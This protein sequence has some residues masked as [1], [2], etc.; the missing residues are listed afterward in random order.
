MKLIDEIV[1]ILSSE[2]GKLTDALIKTKVLLHQIGHK[3]LAEWVNNELNGYEPD[4]ELPS[5]RLL[6]AH[7]R[8]NV[9]SIAWQAQ[10]HPIPLFH[11]TDKERER[12]QTARMSQSLAVIERWARVDEGSLTIPIPMEFNARLGE[13]LDDGVH[14]QSAWSQIDR[15]Q[16]SSV[17]IQVRS[18]LL[19]FIL[20]LRD[21]FSDDMSETEVKA[22]ANSIDAQGLFN[23]T[24]FGDNAT[25]QL[26]QGN[27]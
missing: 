26:G 17:L 1:G 11:L 19:D 24:I 23:N 6:G 21:Q 4:A 22:H 5:Y 7:V 20:E 16:V 13:P 8:A 27:T 3:E 9:A 10:A 12:L 15:T 18:R 25:I 2:D 14:I